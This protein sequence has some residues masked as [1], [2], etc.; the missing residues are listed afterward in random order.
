M[1]LSDVTYTAAKSCQSC[2]T[3]CDPIDRSPPGFSIPGILQAR[4]LEWVSISFS[5]TWKWK[6]KVKSL[7][8]VQLLA[9]PWTA[10]YQA[11]PS[12]GSPGKSTGVGE[13]LI[14]SNKNIFE[15]YYLQVIPE[16]SSSFPYFLIFKSE[17]GNKEFMIWATVR[18]PGLVFVDCIELLH[19]WLQRI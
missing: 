8:R 13:L 12:W 4:I 17:F 16:W 7:S 1:T 14:V 5:K 10:A 6:V 9:T 2:L 19:L 3:L 18:A 15:D 11:P